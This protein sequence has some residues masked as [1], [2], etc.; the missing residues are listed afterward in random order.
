MGGGRERR[1]GRRE[2]VEGVKRVRYCQASSAAPPQPPPTPTP[3]T[4]T[5]KNASTLPMNFLP[6]GHER[7]FGMRP[8][9]AMSTMHAATTLLLFGVCAR[10]CVC[11]CVL[12]CWR[13]QHVGCV[14]VA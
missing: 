5:F 13:R 1:Q 6:A 9:G 7:S 3:P 14:R 2:R 8:P 10:V 4:R 11:V 12:V